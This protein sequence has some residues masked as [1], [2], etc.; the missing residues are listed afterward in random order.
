MSL[1]FCQQN[2]FHHDLFLF[3]SQKKKENILEAMLLLKE[4]KSCATADSARPSIN[5][6]RRP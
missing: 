6:G 2:T 3:N 5:N 4:A 1:K